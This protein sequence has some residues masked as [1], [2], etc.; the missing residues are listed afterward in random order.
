[1]GCVE[2]RPVERYTGPRLQA[3]SLLPPPPPRRR[4]AATATAAPTPRPPS[5]SQQRAAQHAARFEQRGCDLAAKGDVIGLRQWL[6]CGGDPHSRTSAA[7]SQG[8]PL[9]HAACHGKLACMQALLDAGAHM[10]AWSAEGTPLHVALWNYQLAVTYLLVQSGADCLARHEGSTAAQMA[11]DLGFGRIDKPLHSSAALAVPPAVAVP[12][13]AG[14]GGPAAGATLPPDQAAASLCQPSAPPATETFMDRIPSAPPATATLLARLSSPGQPAAAAAVANLKQAVP[15]TGTAAATVSSVESAASS[16]GA[17]G[18]QPG[19]L[20]T[21]SSRGGASSL[22]SGSLATDPLLL[23]VS[24]QASGRPA[25]HALGPGAGSAPSGS[26]H[27]AAAPLKGS[28]GSQALVDVHPWQIDFRE[29]TFICPLGEGSYGKVYLAE[30]CETHV[31]VKV[32]MSLDGTQQA[33]EA[34]D[35]MAQALTLSSPVLENLQKEA[36][37]CERGSVADVLLAARQSA[38]AAA[39]LTVP[40]RLKMALDS[41]LG[42][43][44]LHKRGLIHRDIKSP[45]LLVTADW[46]TK[47]ADFNLSKIVE[48][49]N[50]RL[51]SMAAMNPRLLAPEI[52]RGEPSSNSSDVLSLGVVFHELLTWRIPW[53]DCVSPWLLVGQLMKGAQLP[54]PPRHELPGPDTTSWTGLDQYIAQARRCCAQAPAERP[55]LD[56]IIVELRQLLAATG[57]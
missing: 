4:N 55:G 30:L 54:L 36:E 44:Y 23:W 2:S 42:L 46:V 35:R 21:L 16:C 33:A 43:L 10:N 50:P 15:P 19:D 24:A 51:S 3:V 14:Q 41:S 1:M 48:E 13:P 39:E 37:L 52:L 18:R 47:V 56:S 25:E 22:S 17:Q 31:A 11:L 53:E 26:G 9:H 20:S 7:R 45:N 34:S 5:A 12:E 57:L 8:G 27:A 6:R 40:R 38:E 29:L 49:S 32:L 28:G